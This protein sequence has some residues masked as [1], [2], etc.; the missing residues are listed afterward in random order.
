MPLFD[1][2]TPPD[3]F[4]FGRHARRFHASHFAS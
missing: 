3:Y 1:A 4:D 2:I